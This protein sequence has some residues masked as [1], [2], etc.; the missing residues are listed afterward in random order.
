MATS[1]SDDDYIDVGII[2]SEGGEEEGEEELDGGGGNE[3][4][5]EGDILAGRMWPPWREGWRN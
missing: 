4:G 2:D 5:G 1:D 3:G